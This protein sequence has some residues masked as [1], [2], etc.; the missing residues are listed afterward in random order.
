MRCRPLGD[1]L[2]HYLYRLSETDRGNERKLKLLQMTLR[3]SKSSS[4]GILHLT[5]LL[6]S[7]LGGGK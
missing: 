5:N 6:E 7:F 2:S 3:I 4:L 1:D